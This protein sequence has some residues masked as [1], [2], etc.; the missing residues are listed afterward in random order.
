MLPNRRPQKGP[1]MTVDSATTRETNK[2]A[3]RRAMSG[4]TALDVDAIQAELHD[5]PVVSA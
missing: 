1:D 3:L 4:I 5:A 2:Q